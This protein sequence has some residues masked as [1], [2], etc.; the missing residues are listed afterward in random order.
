MKDRRRGS[1]WTTT[2]LHRARRDAG[3]SYYV[4]DFV[5][6]LQIPLFGSGRGVGAQKGH[7]LR[8]G[9][10]CREARV[11]EGDRESRRD[12]FLFQ[13]FLDLPDLEELDLLFS[14]WC[15]ERLFEWCREC[16]LDLDWDQLLLC[17]ACDN[18]WRA[19]FCSHSRRAL[20]VNACQ[21]S[22]DAVP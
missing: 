1:S 12:L 22:E 9:H 21:S 6:P 15:R 18:S 13:S 11:W 19:S 20:G 3:G 16:H 14:K 17:R 8:L 10:R 7:I 2:K 4:E 5:N